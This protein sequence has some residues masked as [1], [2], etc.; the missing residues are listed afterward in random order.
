MADADPEMASFSAVAARPPLSP[1]RALWLFARSAAV[2]GVFASALYAALYVAKDMRAVAP[3]AAPKPAD[4]INLPAGLELL[5]PLRDAAEFKGVV[6]F[7][8]VV[9]QQLP[10]GTAITPRLD[11][12]QADAT[13]ARRGEL[14]F[15]AQRDAAGHVLGPSL[16]LSESARDAATGAAASAPAS[17]APGTFAATVPCGAITIDARLFFPATGDA[18]QQLTAAHAFTDALA[19]QCTR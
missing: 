11:A 18:A 3:A 2:A 1:L 13:G 14:R 9:P 17:V 6:G 10:T 8:P 4:N 19:A 7:A 15:Q 5:T 16:L 12:T